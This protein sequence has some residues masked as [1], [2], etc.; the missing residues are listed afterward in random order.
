MKT[1]SFVIPTYN[2]YDLLHQVLYDIY[3]KCS[4]VHEV[5]VV[6]D[7]STEES[8]TSG[9]RWWKGNGMLPIR[10]VRM[11]ENSMFLK[12]SNAGLKRATGDIVCLLSNDVRLHGDVVRETILA[13]EENAKRLIGGRLLDFDTGWNTFKGA[14]PFWYIEG[15]MLTTWNTSWKD[16]GYLDERFAPSDMEDVDISTTAMARGYRLFA[17]PADMTQHLGGQ[18]IGFNPAREAITIANKEK[19]RR[20]WIENEK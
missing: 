3:Q 11:K 19:F 2:R 20:K 15:W 13:L 5:I 8:Y 9:L 10:H 14:P 18:S 17:L 1:F 6:D 12:A 16:W 7:C 4:P